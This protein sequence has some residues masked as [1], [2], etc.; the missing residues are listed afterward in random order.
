MQLD[1]REFSTTGEPSGDQRIKFRRGH[2][3]SWVANKALRCNLL[4][5]NQVIAPGDRKTC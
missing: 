3:G 1:T 2:L 5:V 4:L